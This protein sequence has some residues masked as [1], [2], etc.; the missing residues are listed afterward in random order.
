M[1]LRY[2]SS[3]HPATARRSFSQKTLL[4]LVA[5]SHH[6]AG[7]TV[8]SAAAF[9]KQL[10]SSRMMLWGTSLAFPSRIEA[11]LMAV[12]KDNVPHAFQQYSYQACA[13]LD[14]L[15]SPHCM[16]SMA[17][18]AKLCKCLTGWWSLRAL[19]NKRPHSPAPVANIL[20][21]SLPRATI[22]TSMRLPGDWSGRSQ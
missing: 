7:A 2:H 8:Q 6:L 16:S 13:C 5:A 4:P 15:L 14:L 20:L 17:S 12:E 21:A 9:Q 10:L 3:N 11:G 1:Q 18:M 22:L 19:P